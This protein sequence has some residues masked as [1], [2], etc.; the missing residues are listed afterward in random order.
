MYVLFFSNLLQNI[1]K[2]F[3]HQYLTFISNL[4]RHFLPAQTQKAPL[5]LSAYKNPSPPDQKA[6]HLTPVICAHSKRRSRR[7]RVAHAPCAPAGGV[8]ELKSCQSGV[9]RAA[10]PPFDPAAAPPPPAPAKTAPDTQAGYIPPQS[11][12]I[13]T[14]Q[15]T[16][17]TIT[18]KILVK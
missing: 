12:I 1:N 16:C 6:W 13:G 10:G 7:R 4:S 3:P 9:W 2:N 11:L 17:E 18:I 15:H 14:S 5:N 8:Q